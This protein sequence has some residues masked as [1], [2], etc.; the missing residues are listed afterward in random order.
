[1]HRVLIVL[2][3]FVAN[4]DNAGFQHR[5]FKNSAEF[6]PENLES[7]VNFMNKPDESTA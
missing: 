2:H 4:E 6:E 5:L 1:M 3:E 7:Y